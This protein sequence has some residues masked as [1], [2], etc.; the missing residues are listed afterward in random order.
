MSNSLKMDVYDLDLGNNGLNPKLFLYFEVK[1]LH[2][3]SAKCYNKR[4]KGRSC[5][6]S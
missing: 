2:E 1:I 3:K 6:S 4:N 5:S